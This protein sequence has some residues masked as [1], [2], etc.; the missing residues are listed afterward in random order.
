MDAN[1]RFIDLGIWADVFIGI[2]AAIIIYALNPPDGALQLIFITLTAGIGGSAILKSYIKGTQAT[3]HDRLAAQ[4]MQLAEYAI[5]V[6]NPHE[7]LDPKSI[8]VDVTG[9]IN[10]NL[11]QKQLDILK[12]ER[13]KTKRA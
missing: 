1:V 5:N 8:E 6:A 4:S 3:E 13:R 7:T 9:K 11:L 12:E 2:L 10:L